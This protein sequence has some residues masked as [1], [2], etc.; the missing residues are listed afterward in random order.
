MHRLFYG[1]FDFEHEL[2]DPNG[3]QRS[4]A[5]RR[6]LAERA[7]V[8]TALADDGDVIW[9]PEAIPDSFWEELAASGLPRVRGV[10]DIKGASFD[11]FELAPWGWS[12][13]MLDLSRQ[14]ISQYQMAVID[15]A[16]VGNSRRWSLALEREFG[17][18]LPGSACIERFEDFSPTVASS[19]SYYGHSPSD[20]RWVIK[21]NFGM[22]G[23]E[24]ILG[25]GPTLSESHRHWMQRRLAADRAV[26]FEPWIP[27][28]EEVGLQF[29]IPSRSNGPPRLEGITPLISAAHGGYLGSRISLVEDVPNEWQ[30]SVAVALQAAE[31]LQELGYFGPLGIDAA[32]HE[33]PNGDVMMRP[34]Q[35]INV[36]FTMG[37][38]AL[39]FKRLLHHSEYGVWQHRT[40][41]DISCPVS[42]PNAPTRIIRTSPVVV[43]STPSKHLSEVLIFSVCDNKTNQT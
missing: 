31:R 16:Q 18:A 36:R 27:I 14:P 10:T 24:R 39:G 30:S 23:R 28:R 9:T 43:N 41:T 42:P 6:M 3:W 25:I 19:A 32:Q 1:N 29:T 20:H 15:A 38:L 17:V 22:A 2:A 8:W 12:R 35:D 40:P 21:S 7:S 13:R 4:T 34:L 37:R 26:F 33:L 5:I 11:E